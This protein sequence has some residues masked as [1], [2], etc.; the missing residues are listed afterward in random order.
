MNDVCVLTL[1]GQLPPPLDEVEPPDDAVPLDP[2]DE[3]PE[4]DVGPPL[5]P[6]EPTPL[7]PP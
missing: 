4:E 7:D 1:A 3:A 2:P 5:V 6:D